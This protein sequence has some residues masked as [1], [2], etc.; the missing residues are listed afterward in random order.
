[1]TEPTPHGV[2]APRV[3]FTKLH[4]DATIP[5]K[6]HETD[7]GYDLSALIRFPGRPY[8][9][10]RLNPGQ[11]LVVSTGIACALPAGTVG[12]V[13]VRSSLGFKHHITLSNSVGVVDA[14]YRGELKVSLH[15]TGRDAFYV[16]HGDRIAQL[17][18]TPLVTCLVAVEADS[19][20]EADR[21]DAG[22]GSTGR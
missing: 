9:D 3:I 1:M 19:L 21:G 15:N 2:S 11:H 8:E 20:P 7:A 5:S 13:Y 14:G 4:E 6:A 22:F 18:V 17:V 12:L 16:R 10:L